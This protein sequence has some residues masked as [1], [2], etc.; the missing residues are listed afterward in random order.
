MSI[1]SY[2]SKEVGRYQSRLDAETDVQLEE[3]IAAIN[4]G[5]EEGEDLA[6]TILSALGGEEALAVVREAL[7]HKL[8]KDAMND[9]AEIKAIRKLERQ[10]YFGQEE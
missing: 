8:L 1:D 3:M 6:Q 5:A 7:T 2:S 4:E 10:R 9:I